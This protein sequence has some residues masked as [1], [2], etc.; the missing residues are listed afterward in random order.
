MAQT[1]TEILQLTRDLS[2]QQSSNNISPTDLTAYVNNWYQNKLPSELTL[3]LDRVW[4]LI[5]IP[6]QDKYTVGAEYRTL[7]GSVRVNGENI[8]FYT[9]P[10]IFYA[11]YPDSWT[12][13]QTFGTG[14][15][16]TVTFGGTL[17]NGYRLVPE[18][19]AIGDTVETFTDDGAGVLTGSA[20]GTGTITYSSGAVSV[21]FNG[22]PADGVAVS[23]SYAVYNE[24]EPIAALYTNQDTDDGGNAELVFRPI[25]DSNY[26]VEVDYEARPAALSGGGS[27]PLQKSWG[28]LIAYGTAIDILERYGSF[29]EA[30]TL[31]RSYQ[32][33][34]DTVLSREATV[35]SNNRPIPRW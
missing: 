30:E 34:L 29:D 5:T 8:G 23:A 22:A 1:L 35:M 18:T 25:P 4:R 33:I 20:G 27:E 11:T 15:A 14:D 19:L 12:N 31:K 2:G 3:G 10:S 28:D 26:N 6:Y 32:R 24:S 13:D 21:T 9:N 17:G 7:I 16:S